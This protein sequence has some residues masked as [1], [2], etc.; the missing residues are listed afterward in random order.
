MTTPPSTS[1]DY[2]IPLV[3]VLMHRR[4]LLLALVCALALAMATS[5]FGA[6]W[7]T[8]VKEEVPGVVA[9]VMQGT[10][11]L[12][13]EIHA[14]R[15]P[16]LW[17]GQ[18]VELTVRQPLGGPSAVVRGIVRSIAPVRPAGS[19]AAGTPVVVEV[20]TI[21]VPASWYAAL[22]DGG[23]HE[24]SLTLRSRRALALFVERGGGLDPVA[25]SLAARPAGGGETRTGGMP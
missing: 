22:E 1:R 17:A 8:R 23:R 9:G 13:I 3:G 16:L 10:G 21:G 20:E 24:V 19:G 15:A 14:R 25:R 4:W 6:L 12:A 7:I 2:E 18:R 11:R 5:L